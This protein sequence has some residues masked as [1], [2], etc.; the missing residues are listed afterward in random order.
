MI[1]GI[2]LAAGQSSRMGGSKALLPLSPGG[3]TFVAALIR[4]LLDGG[5]ADVLVVGR[6]DDSALRDEAERGGARFVGNPRHELGQLSS[7]LAGLNVADRPGV[8][9]VLVTPVDAPRIAAGSVAALVQA[10]RESGAPVVRPVHEGRHGH[11]VIFSRAVFDALRSADFS[12]GAKA[13]VRAQGDR[14]MNVEIA[15]PAVLDDIDTPADY[16]NM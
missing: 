3:S 7:L 8:T 5:I 1:P 12:V 6:P 16:E 11:P 13:V 14:V 4:S 2:I 15:D 9:G 10:F